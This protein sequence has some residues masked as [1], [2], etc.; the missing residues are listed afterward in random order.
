[1]VNLPF[2]LNCKWD[3]EIGIKDISSV[4]VYALWSMHC[5]HCFAWTILLETEMLESGFRN[6]RVV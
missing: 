3:V 5:V 1:M 2:R 6:Q 4:Y